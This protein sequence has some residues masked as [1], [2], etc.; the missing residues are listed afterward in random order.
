M[1]IVYIAHPIGAINPTDRKDAE[2][3]VTHNLERIKLIN[4]QIN[5][6]EQDVV[7]FAPYFLDCVSMK[8]DIPEERARGILND[9]AL[10]ASGFISEIRLYGGRISKGMLDE[11]K[12]AFSC[13]IPVIP[14]TPGTEL[15]FSEIL[16]KI[17]L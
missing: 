8:D 11:I 9:K 4:R 17:V 5:L 3:Q 13:G 12:F 14:M 15:E 10:I 7:P 1:K 2:L 6:N 16:K